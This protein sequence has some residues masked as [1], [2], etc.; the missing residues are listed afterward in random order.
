ME[1]IAEEMETMEDLEEIDICD[2]WPGGNSTISTYN[3]S[4][5]KW[6]DFTQYEG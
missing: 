1:E 4:T 3:D 5:Y 2:F 6:H